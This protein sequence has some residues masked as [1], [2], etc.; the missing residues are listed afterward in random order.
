MKL[1]VCTDGSPAAEQAALLVGKLGL[2]QDVAITLLGVVDEHGDASALEASFDRMAKL[3]DGAQ[4][5]LARKIRRGDS[6]EQIL[7]EAV[8]HAYDLVVVG[9]GGQHHGLLHFKVGSTTSKLARKLHTHFLVARNIPN[10]VKK[11]LV[12][13]GAEA[14]AVDTMR[15]SGQMLAGLPAEITVLHVMSQISLKPGSIPEELIATAETA[16]AKNTREGQHLQRA[17]QQLSQ[18]GITGSIIP[19]LRHG[20]VVDEVLAEVRQGKYDIMVVGAHYQP[21]QNR[22]LGILL[23][24]VTDQL[25]NQAPCSV[26]IV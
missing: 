11:V 8:A 22:W 12:C 20:L 21:G 1:L 6:Y 9:G 23:D 4:L 19:R 18:A 25:I 7:E 15:V 3:L 14:P 5:N 2:S 17:M 26:L 24:D 10:Q 13:T 16:I